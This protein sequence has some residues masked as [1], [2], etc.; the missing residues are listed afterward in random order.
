MSSRNVS[1]AKGGSRVVI[2][3]VA[4]KYGSVVFMKRKKDLQDKL[5][6]LLAELNGPKGFSAQVDEMIVDLS[7]EKV[8]TTKRHMFSHLLRFTTQLHFPTRL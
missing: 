6:I 1:P 2:E 4:D 8:V 5:A 7:T 3:E